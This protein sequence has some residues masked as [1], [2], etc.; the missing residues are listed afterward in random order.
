MERD[1]R[2]R[3]EAEM[4]TQASG[5]ARCSNRPSGWAH[6]LPRPSVLLSQRQ[7]HCL[8]GNGISMRL[9]WHPLTR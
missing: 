2:H 1:G 5:A 7:R 9:E 4:S 3:G 8:H 6:G